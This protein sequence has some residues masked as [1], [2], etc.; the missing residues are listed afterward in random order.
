MGSGYVVMDVVSNPAKVWSTL[1]DFDNYA[2]MVPTIRKVRVTSRF[3]TITKG[4]FSLSKF[5]F[6]LGVVHKHRPEDS[7]LD[8]FL[9]PDAAQYENI[10]EMAEGFWFVD[11][12]PSDR[13]E[14]YTRVYMVATVKVNSLVPLW[15]VEYA[16]ERAF[17]R[18]TSWFQPYI[19]DGTSVSK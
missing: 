14:G 5:R 4:I 16:A 19:E 8:F 7:R 2:D 18:A 17:K 11:E 6:R 10:L 3:K 1:L 12:R 15:L 9:D 13:P